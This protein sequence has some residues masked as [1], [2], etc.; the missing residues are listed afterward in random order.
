MKGR[1]FRTRHRLWSG[2]ETLVQGLLGGI[3]QARRAGERIG[4]R[5]E[6]T[7][8]VALGYPCMSILRPRPLAQERID[9]FVAL[10]ADKRER[11]R[12]VGAG[13]FFLGLSGFAAEPRQPIGAR[14]G[15]VPSFPS[16]AIFV[17]LNPRRPQ[18]P[19]LHRSI[20]TLFRFALTQPRGFPSPWENTTSQPSGCDR[21]RS[22]NSPTGKSN[23]CHNGSTR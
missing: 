2:E 6:I 19:R 4:L 9:C 16:P 14:A 20:S 7:D 22:A 10:Q 17:S 11:E 15:P 8:M 23:D 12:V 1:G 13:L 5:H 21:P 3:S 18:L